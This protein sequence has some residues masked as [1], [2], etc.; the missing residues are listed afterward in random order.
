MVPVHQ[1]RSMDEYHL[2]EGLAVGWQREWIWRWTGVQTSSTAAEPRVRRA[3][4]RRRSGE[5]GSHEWLSVADR[6]GDHHRRCARLG[7][8]RL[9][10]L[11]EALWIPIHKVP[12]IVD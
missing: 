10:A 4:A 6:D 9:L 8:L 2:H 1:T 3:C 7:G 11:V 12:L 5:H